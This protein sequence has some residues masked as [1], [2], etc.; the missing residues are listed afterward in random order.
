VYFRIQSVE[1]VEKSIAAIHGVK[2]SIKCD[3]HQTVLEK[4]DN[5]RVDGLNKN[6]HPYRLSTYSINALTAI[7]KNRN[8]DENELT[9]SETECGQSIEI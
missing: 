8:S 6:S 4:A 1:N 9:P 5:R 2:F 3:Y 7:A